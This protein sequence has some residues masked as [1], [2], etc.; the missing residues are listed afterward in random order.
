MVETMV[1][2]LTRE[3]R[4][5]RSQRRSLTTLNWPSSVQRWTHSRR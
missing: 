4:R 2:L 1:V 3:R 5:R